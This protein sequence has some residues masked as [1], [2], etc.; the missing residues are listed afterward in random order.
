MS[1]F[2]MMADTL[3]DAISRVRHAAAPDDERPILRTILIERRGD[4]L[5]FVASDNYRL[6]TFGVADV[7]GPDEDAAW[8]PAI[9]TIDDVTVILAFLKEIEEDRAVRVS[10]DGQTLTLAPTSLFVEMTGSLAVG[11]FGGEYPDIDAIW[12]AT[13]PFVARFRAEY[14]AGLVKGVGRR[15]HV[16]LHISEPTAPALFRDPVED[17]AEVIM[18]VRTGSDIAV[19]RAGVES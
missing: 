6:A 8:D 14:L 19:E 5:R 4:G 11:L 2:I 3:A 1:S 16:T 7:W 9:V 13:G 12:P 10:H 17:Y 15:G 18:P